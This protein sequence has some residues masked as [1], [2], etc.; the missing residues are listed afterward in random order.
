[1][2][3]TLG[4]DD[5]S[6][7]VYRAMLV[8]PSEGVTALAKRLGMGDSD[9]RE[10]LDALSSLSLIRPSVG[11][12]A[13]FLMVSPE[14]AMELLLT[15]RQADLA[16]QQE[17]LEASRAAAAQ[18]IAEYSVLNRGQGGSESEQ[19]VGTDAIRLRL[20]RL[21][22]QARSEV[23]TFAPGGAHR[24]EDLQ[25]SRGPNEALLDRGVRMRTV[26]L[27]SV[28]NHQ[29]TLEHVAWL[30]SRGGRVRTAPAL[31][32]RMIIIDRHLAVLPTDISDARA[33]AA[34]LTGPGVVAA[35]CALFEQVWSTAAPLGDTPSAD[36][37]GLSP[38]EAE[39]LRLLASGLTDEAMAKRLGVSP[40]TARRIAADL[41]DRLEA[42][43]RFQAGVHA[44]QNGWL[45]K[46]RH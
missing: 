46:S 19:L 28:R 3:E 33:G 22:E 38:Q 14:V 6:E 20:A 25:A 13:E 8:H 43:S 16:A 39:A 17:R 12:G 35:L 36:S 44:V 27:D 11:E 41:M 4:L 18:L 7:Q 5:R 45:P 40:R 15:R 9:V 26:Y 23:M 32:V 1:M 24:T 31:P 37:R 30:N 29:P 21:G 10:S 34:V 2:L 42:R